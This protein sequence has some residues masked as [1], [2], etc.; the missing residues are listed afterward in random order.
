MKRESF[1][2]GEIDEL[3][4]QTWQ[5]PGVGSK[6]IGF[7]I[8]HSSG[9]VLQTTAVTPEQMLAYYA[10]TA[11]YVN[12]NNNGGP[13]EK[14]V[15]D[16]SR[17]IH[18]VN[19]LI[20]EQPKSALQIGSSDGYTLSRFRDSGIEQVLG[21]DPS[22]ASRNFAKQTYS[23]ES[24]AGS[25]EDFECDQKFDLLVLT[26]IL[27]HLYNPIDVLLKIK[28]YLNDSGH[29]LIEVPLWER[30]DL[31]PIGVLTFEHVNY[32]CENSL[33]LLMQKTGFDVVHI[34]KNFNTNQYPVISL[35]AKNNLNS[36]TIPTPRNNY[37]TNREILKKH[38]EV[39][40]QSWSDASEKIKK[41]LNTQK[42]LYI[43]GGGI[44]TTQMLAS[45]N[46][47][48]Y[49]AIQAIF[50]SSPSK[51]GKQLGNYEIIDPK[52]LKTLDAGTNILVSSAASETNIVKF[53]QSKRQDLNIIKLYEAV[54]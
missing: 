1:F 29:V 34:S 35:I 53:I 41:Q 51:W 10:H 46:I 47:E 22:E 37:D 28:H 42:K 52:R 40:K 45:T 7:G 31:Q 54:V 48:T 20:P 3:I 25:A 18:L 33:L 16:L 8:C 23:I 36:S 17:F 49:Q 38:L 30:V 27:E 12:P 6:H 5:I 13:Q 39:T 50:D 21:V 44:H 14:K 26:H 43:Y 15:R 24:I 19:D 11:T 2:G 4:S 32:F 9:L